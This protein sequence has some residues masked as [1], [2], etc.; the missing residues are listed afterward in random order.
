MLEVGIQALESMSADMVILCRM[1]LNA[2]TSY[3][4]YLAHGKLYFTRK[5][6]GAEAS[7]QRR[8]P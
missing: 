1:H 7:R 3:H 8:R 4:G 6:G 2:N 5:W